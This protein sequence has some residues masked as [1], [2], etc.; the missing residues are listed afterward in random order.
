MALLVREALVGNPERLDQRTLGI[1]VF[2]QNAA[3]FDPRRNPIVR[4]QVSKLRHE[5][6]RYY[7]D[8]CDEPIRL[9]I[10]RGQYGLVFKRAV[11][12]GSVS[13]EAGPPAIE[14]P[15][16]SMVSRVSL[17]GGHSLSPVP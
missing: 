13:A 8:R 9:E 3:N 7:G 12:K 10:P 14:T 6:Q 16:T 1:E 17:E 15:R 5:L 11:P 4:V 2:E